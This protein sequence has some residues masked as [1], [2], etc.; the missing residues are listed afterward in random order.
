MII[1]INVIIFYCVYP[2]SDTVMHAACCIQTST[3]Y[4]ALH[5][6]SALCAT[7]RTQ[8]FWSRQDNNITFLIRYYRSNIY[9]MYANQIT[10]C[11][12]RYQFYFIFFFFF[13]YISIIFQAT[14]L[15]IKLLSDIAPEVIII[16]VYRYMVAGYN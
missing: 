14:A 16:V 8:S 2:P 10:Q 5:N 4:I 6:R 3:K 7:I 1:V 9:S 13:S 15:I 12:L 11:A